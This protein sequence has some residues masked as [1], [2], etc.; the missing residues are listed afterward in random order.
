MEPRGNTMRKSNHSRRLWLAVPTLTYLLF[1]CG[2]ETNEGVTDSESGV[3]G[4]LSIEPSAA[5]V[6]ATA[7]QS[8]TFTVVG[9]RLPYNW[10][11]N[12]TDIGTLTAHGKRGVYSVREGSGANVVLVTDAGGNSVSARIVQGE[13][14]ESSLAISPAVAN[15][16][17]NQA[18]EIFTA[19]GGQP[20]Y[21]WS[22]SASQLG[23][24]RAQGNNAVYNR[25]PNGGSLFVRVTDSLG[26][27]VGAALTQEPPTPEEL[28][29]SAGPTT[30]DNDGDKSVL[31]ATGGRPPYQWSVTDAALGSIIGSSTKSSTV[32]MRNHNGDNVVVLRDANNTVF[33]LRIEQP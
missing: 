8:V 7:G 29:A 4:V 3:R 22:L 16:P 14:S 30:L 33:N 2:C 5:V 11:I 25:G 6:D 1:A 13:I 21:R 19:S 12:N 15:M 20:P 18:T 32:Y 27:T 26:H 24:L 28:K 17:P 23:S 10:Q 31:T 9:G